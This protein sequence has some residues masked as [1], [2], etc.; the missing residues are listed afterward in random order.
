MY[1]NVIC[2]YP[3]PKEIQ[4][5]CFQTKDFDSNLDTYIIKKNGKLNYEGIWKIRNLNFTGEFNFYTM[6]FNEDHS[7]IWYEYKAT[8][9]DGNLISLE[10]VECS[11]L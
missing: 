8:F 4:N 9:K 6:L 1:D 5:E 7:H 10:K 2:N 3:L 11:W